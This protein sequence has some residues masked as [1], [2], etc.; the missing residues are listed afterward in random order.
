MQRARL[1][2]DVAVHL[3]LYATCLTTAVH[4]HKVHNNRRN[5][6]HSLSYLCRIT[7]L[8]LSYVVR[9]LQRVC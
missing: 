1:F 9:S 5:I 8:A 7:L 3:L 2:L 4:R 6:A